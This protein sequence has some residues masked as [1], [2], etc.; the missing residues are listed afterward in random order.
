VVLAIEPPDGGLGFF[1]GAHFHEGEP[2]AAPAFAVRDDLGTDDSA[3]R[4]E[5]RFQIGTGD[6][7]AQIPYVQLLSQDQI[8]SAKG[9]S[10]NGV[11]RKKRTSQPI[12][13]SA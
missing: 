2:L 10:P 6:A 4:R 3:K 7:V 8:S 1:V 12:G 11:S 9:Q 5:Q 13:R